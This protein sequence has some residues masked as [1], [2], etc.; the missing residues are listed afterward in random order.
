MGADGF[1][2]DPTMSYSLEVRCHQCGL[3]VEE[4]DPPINYHHACIRGDRLAVNVDIENYE[5]R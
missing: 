2:I 3:P 4:N 1:I 5:A